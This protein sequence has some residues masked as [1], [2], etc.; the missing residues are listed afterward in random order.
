M[1]F[2]KC[3]KTS[4]VISLI[5][6]AVLINEIVYNYAVFF[7]FRIVIKF[8]YFIKLKLFKRLHYSL[9]KLNDIFCI[10]EITLYGYS[11]FCIVHDNVIEYIYE[12]IAKQ[13][14][15][16]LY[17]ANETFSIAYLGMG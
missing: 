10:H 13:C 11:Y 12:N 17:A 6:I 7:S 9:E 5:I 8:I 14:W 3:N 16:I 1:D 15:S 4:L 2:Y